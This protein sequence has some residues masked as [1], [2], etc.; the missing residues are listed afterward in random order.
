MGIDTRKGVIRRFRFLDECKTKL[1]SASTNLKQNV[2]TLLPAQFFLPHISLPVVTL[3]Q[4]NLYFP[5]AKRFLVFSLHARTRSLD[6]SPQLLPKGSTHSLHGLHE[7]MI[8]S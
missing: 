7:D 2:Y 8:P 1:I 4:A 6:L 3:L 5:N